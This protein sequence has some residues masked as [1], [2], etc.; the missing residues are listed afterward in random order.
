MVG[1][2][3]SPVKFHVIDA[4]TTYHLLLGKIWMHRYD[5]I[6]STFYQYLKG[7]WKEKVMEVLA[8]TNPFFAEEAHFTEAVFFNEFADG[9]VT[10]KPLN[11]IR[12]PDWTT[13]EGPTV[14]PSRMPKPAT[15]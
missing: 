3:K 4:P 8:S 15:K 10:P 11:A 5:V 14:E 12:L 2:I 7:I 6:P 9:E 1:K 13:T